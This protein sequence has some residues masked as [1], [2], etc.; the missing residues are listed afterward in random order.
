VSE[1]ETVARLLDSLLAERDLAGAIPFATVQEGKRLPGVDGGPPIESLS[2]YALSD[3]G[4]VYRY[5]LAWDDSRR[6]HVLQ[7][8]SRVDKLGV[9]ARDREY[10]AAR[11][12]LKRRHESRSDPDR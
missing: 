7:P 3:D 12:K 10:L 11:R 5:W 9:L 1:R 6:R 4:R 8:F 2:G